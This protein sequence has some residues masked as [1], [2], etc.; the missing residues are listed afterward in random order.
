M[1]RSGS[2]LCRMIFLFCFVFNSG[3]STSASERCNNSHLYKARAAAKQIQN[4]EVSM[5]VCII[6]GCNY[7]YDLQKRYKHQKLIYNNNIKCAR[8]IEREQQEQA[9][10]NFS[11]N[12]S[13]LIE[14]IMRSPGAHNSPSVPQQGRF[15]TTAGC[16]LP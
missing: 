3:L 5:S 16:T 7:H 13:K 10:R 14:G 8:F 9:I 6:V 12:Y 11:K 2:H 4:I 15:C 1:I